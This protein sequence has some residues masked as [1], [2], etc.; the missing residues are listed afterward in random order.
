MVTTQLRRWWDLHTKTNVKS[1]RIVKITDVVEENP[2]VK[3]LMFRDPN[4]AFAGQ[5]VM[6]WIP[7]VDEIPMSISQN[8]EYK[9]M[10]IKQIGAATNALNNLK[11]GDKIGIRGPYGTFFRSRG[12]K[13]LVVAGGIGIA[14]IL[15]FIETNNREDAE[16]YVALG[17]VT[18]SELVF[19]QRLQGKCN[20]LY[21]ATDDGSVG[22]HGF[23]T[24][25]A[26]EVVLREGIDEIFTCGP[27][28]MIKKMV[29]FAKENNILIQASLERYMKCGVGLCD[30]CAI[31]GL[32]V[33]RDGPVFSEKV[34][35][36]LDDLGNYKRDRCGRKVK[37]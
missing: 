9:G 12:K 11:T 8:G 29:D 5:F 10:T 27:E 26:K 14:P 13:I 25:L 22:Y 2:N 20:E 31:D 36:S 6:V 35:F 3:T 33:C 28:I 37:V 18:S 19:D 30:S 24:D 34:L 1:Q 32:H 4:N 16:V 15:P 23:V 17:A 21:M 7:K